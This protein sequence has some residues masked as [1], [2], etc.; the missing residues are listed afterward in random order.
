MNKL[1]QLSR[2]EVLA[3]YQTQRLGKDGAPIEVW[4]TATALLDEH[5]QQYAVAT[6]ERG[7]GDD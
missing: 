5:G 3:P 2:A 6:T 1:L 7:P 4:I